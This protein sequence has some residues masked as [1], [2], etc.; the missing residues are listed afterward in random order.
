[1]TESVIQS[2]PLPRD[3]SSSISPSLIIVLCLSLIKRCYTLSYHDF[4]FLKPKNNVVTI[5]PQ[6]IYPDNISL[7]VC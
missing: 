2:E 6:L 7:S 1:M 4:I 3:L 5:Y